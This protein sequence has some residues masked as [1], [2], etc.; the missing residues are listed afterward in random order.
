MPELQSA[1]NRGITPEEAEAIE[2]FKKISEKLV[3]PSIGNPLPQRRQWILPPID[4]KT[5]GDISMSCGILTSVGTATSQ[6]QGTSAQET[7][8]GGAYEIDSSKQTGRK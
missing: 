5:L 8:A 3:V 7:A 6:A 4:Q 1:Q 2:I